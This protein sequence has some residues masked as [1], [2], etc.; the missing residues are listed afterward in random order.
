MLMMK[1]NV[2]IAT[3]VVKAGLRDDNMMKSLL[4]VTTHFDSISASGCQNWPPKSSDMMKM[5]RR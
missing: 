3:A 4:I 2:D 5:K 1:I